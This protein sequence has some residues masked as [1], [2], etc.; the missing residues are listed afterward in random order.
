MDITM[1]KLSPRAQNTLK[2]N[3][4]ETAEQLAG[5]SKAQILGFNKVGLKTLW[6]LESWLNSNGLKFRK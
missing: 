5:Y 4:I 6:E 3:N 2:A 1:D